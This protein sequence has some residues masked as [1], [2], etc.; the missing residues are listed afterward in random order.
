MSEQ[1]M[2]S[3]EYQRGF[4]QGYRQGK[5]HGWAAGYNQGIVHGKDIGSGKMTTQADYDRLKVMECA[6]TDDKNTLRTPTAN[7]RHGKR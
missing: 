6:A 5:D 7:Q 2:T 4:E 1:A 3:A